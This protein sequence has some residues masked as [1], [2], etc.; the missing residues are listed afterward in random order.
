MALL[1]DVGRR[2]GASA[3]AQVDLGMRVHRNRPLSELGPMAAEVL[4]V[5]LERSRS[6]LASNEVRA[7]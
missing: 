4:S 2:Y 1:I 5:A 7:D 3:I 6:E